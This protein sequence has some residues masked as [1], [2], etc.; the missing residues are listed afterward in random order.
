MKILHILYLFFH[1]GIAV[2]AQ[3]PLFTDISDLAGTG[4]GSSN[5]G[6]IVG[7]F[8][9]D[10]FEDLFIPANIS[11]NRLF[12]NMGDGT[13]QDITAGSGIETGGLTKTGAWGDIDNDG[14]LDLFIGNYYTSSYPFQNY[15]YVN[16]GDGTFTDISISSNVATS[17][18]TRSAHMVDLNLD[19]YLDIYICS[20]AQEN[21]L[22]TNNGNLTFTNTTS[23]SGLFDDLISMGA[24][25]F[26]YDNDG[27]QDVYL[28][29]DN[30]QPNIMYENNGSGVFTD[31]SIETGLNVS[32]QGMGVD[33]GDINNDGHLDLY[34][35]NLGPNFLLLNNGSG[36]FTEI[37]EAAGVADV[38]MG[39]GCFF[40]DYDNDG[41]EDIYVVNDSQFSPVSNKLYKNNGDS[42][43]TIVSENT[44]LASFYNGKGG[45]WADLNNDGYAEILV[46]NGQVEIGVQIFENQH[47]ENNWIGFDLVGI[48]DTPD[49]CG[50]RVQV[51][52]IN[53][54]KIDE[55]TCGSSYAAMSSRRVY[56]G[57]GAG[58]V[59][60]ILI[61]WPNGTTDYFETLPVNQIH[62][63]QQG[64]TGT[65]VD[66]DGYTI[67]EDC[68]DSNEAINAGI[69][70]MPYNGLDDDCNPSTPDDD[71]DGDGYGLEFDCDDANNLINPDI[72]EMVYNG[73]DDD[74]DPSTLDDDLDGDGSI[75]TEDCDDNNENINSAII[76]IP[77]D[78][79]DN[80]C[81]PSTLDDDL[82][83]DGFVQLEDCDD[84]NAEAN[85]DGTEIAN[86]GIDEDCN[87]EDLFISVSE[88]PDLL[89]E[90]FP[91]PAV[92]EIQ[93]KL[94]Q[95]VE[96]KVRIIDITGR[97]LL[98]EHKEGK[99]DVR[100]LC[101][102][103][104]LLELSTENYRFIKTSRFEVQR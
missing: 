16:N 32:G 2:I 35:T 12:K 89:L 34:V 61:T 5:N 68:D 87:G 8:D 93:I 100:E 42:T 64:Y 62:E 11:P 13:F 78:G 25:F 29:H 48:E 38:G 27:D 47:S 28:T 46:A 91:N 80:D 76:E 98:L 69:T 58:D 21:I 52:T 95:N 96:Y 65:D 20:L 37:A 83:E 36:H 31:V 66:G 86:N 63:I 97:A 74:C 70:E 102:G 4:N 41:W 26:D 22:W 103:I 24:V 53:G 90:L 82:D 45:T 59:S 99:I 67:L 23:A 49:A 54:V 60:E 57:L 44:D 94:N 3:N 14:D 51:N 40:L 71:L 50:T 18:Q 9:N 72:T 43:F 39:W 15:L 1:T 88:L 75:A 92:S 7:D 101:N 85:P 84:N 77:Y 10:G 19:G 30:Y 73:Q 79:I 81:N 6:V 104:Y 55:V 17:S 33:H 56:F